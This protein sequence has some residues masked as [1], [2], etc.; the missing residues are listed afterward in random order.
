M[1]PTRLDGSA[2][3][4]QYDPKAVA[5]YDIAHEGAQV[6]AVAH[7]DGFD[8]LDGTHPRSV[9]VLAGDALSAQAAHLVVALHSPL[10]LPV[11]VVR[12]LPAYVGALDV[13]VILSQVP[14][15]EDLA[16]AM[17]VGHTRGTTIILA[18]PAGPLQEEAPA[19]SIVIPPVPMVEDAG[20]ARAAATVMAVLD[21]LAFGAADARYRLHEISEGVDQQLARCSPDRE[22][23]NPAEDLAVLARQTRLG[24]AVVHCGR[25]GVD[26][27]LAALVAQCWTEAAFPSSAVEAELVPL[28]LGR[29]GPEDPFHDPFLD[30]PKASAPSVVDWSN[31]RI[32]LAGHVGEETEVASHTRALERW[33]R[34]FGF[35][36]QAEAAIALAT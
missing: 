15:R 22:T 20:S 31:R 3:A 8:A 35:L 7:A 32:T 36:V 11:T 23:L 5:F 25:G 29:F 13:V 14:D 28:M 26:Q 21:T 17:S 10:R 34:A 12:E 6:R 18:A 9:V 27:A 16:R 1:T 33:H 19:D 2:P 24:T 30:G 4:T